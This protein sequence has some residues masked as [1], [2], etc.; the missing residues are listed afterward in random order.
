M[1]QEFARIYDKL[2]FDIDYKKYSDIIKSNI[3]Y[4]TGL[5]ILEIG[6]G[7][8]NMTKYFIDSSK[9]YYGLDP[10]VEMLEVASSKLNEFKNLR[11]LNIGIE[12][13]EMD[14]YFDLAFS[15]L[16]TMNYILDIKMLNESFKRVYN[17]LKPG[18]YFTFDINSLDKIERVLGNNSYIYEYENIFYTWQNYYD[19]KE[20]KVEMILDFFIKERDRYIRITEEQI[21]KYHSPEELSKTLEEI[22][23]NIIKIVDFDTGKDVKS[24]SQRILLICQK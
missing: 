10:S 6:M 1:Y 21:Q 20:Q 8:G 16:D 23:Y 2:V 24:T 3:S 7:T 14:N 13:L 15:T 12:E 19:D 5:R 18:G 4:K 9:E 11:Y 22:G 17:S